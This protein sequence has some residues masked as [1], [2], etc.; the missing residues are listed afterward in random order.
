MTGI[1]FASFLVKKF[2]ILK[3]LLGGIIGQSIACTLSMLLLKWQTPVFVGGVTFI[4]DFFQGIMNTLLII[5]ISSFCKGVLNVYQF[6]IFSTISSVSRTLATYTLNIM[7]NYIGWN[8]IFCVPLICCG[9]VTV[10][11]AFL[12]RRAVFGL[13]WR[14]GEDRGDR[15]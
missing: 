11:L 7:S 2:G 9:P 4:Q 8:A 1:P 12:S 3:A 15:S 14:K 10:L 6:T 5:Y 13:A